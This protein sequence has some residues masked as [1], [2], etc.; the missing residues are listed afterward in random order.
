MNIFLE[1]LFVFVIIICFNQF[2]WKL[3]HFLGVKFSKQLATTVDFITSSFMA[4]WLVYN[5]HY[6]LA[7][8]GMTLL[9]KQN[10]DK[11]FQKRLAD[12]LDSERKKELDNKEST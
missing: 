2:S 12:V 10:L 6:I 8:I 9:V 1:Y 3:Y 5:G 4:A 7:I 11:E